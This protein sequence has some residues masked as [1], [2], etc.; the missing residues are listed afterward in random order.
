MVANQTECSRLEQRSIIKFLVADKRK[1]Y[2]IY[3]L[4]CDVYRK[5]Y[6]SQK[7]FHKWAR[8][9]FAASL[10]QKDIP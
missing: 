5:A 2:E 3:R 1:P 7:N 4:M 10:S 8:K 6:F 9:E